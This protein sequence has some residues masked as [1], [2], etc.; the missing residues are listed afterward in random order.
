MHYLACQHWLKFQT[1][2]KTFWQILVKNITQ[3]R[4]KWQF[5]LYPI[6]LK[7][8]QY[9][10][11]FNTFHFLKTDGVNR[12][13]AERTSKKTIKKCQEFIKILIL[14]SLKNGL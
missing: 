14:A 6:S 7:L 1:K 3:K 4:L 10:Y 9:V 13:V 5:L 11:H 12:S 2:L 8:V